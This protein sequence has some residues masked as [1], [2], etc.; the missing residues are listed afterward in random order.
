[1]QLYDFS[2]SLHAFSYMF[3]RIGWTELPNYLYWNAARKQQTSDKTV[4]CQAAAYVRVV[5]RGRV[6]QV[7]REQPALRAVVPVATIDKAQP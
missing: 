7:Q 4:N 6:V 3:S 1:M 2:Y 5:V